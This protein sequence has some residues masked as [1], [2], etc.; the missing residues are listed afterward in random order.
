MI[1]LIEKM[2]AIYQNTDK[3]DII[4]AAAQRRLGLFG[5]EKT[6]MSE[7]AGDVSMS[8]AAL[9]YYFPDKES[10][11]KAVIEKE[12]VDFFKRIKPVIESI[13]SPQER[14]MAYVKLRIGYFREFMNLSKFRI[15]NPESATPMLRELFHKFRSQESLYF[16]ELL[17]Y[18]KDSGVFH[19]ENAYALSQLFLDILKGLRLA[20][21]PHKQYIELKEEEIDLI[22]A[23]AVE[24]TEIFIRGLLYSGSDLP[25]DPV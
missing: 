25:V 12:L 8:K 13:Q 17:Q 4:I 1:V 10:I 14:L 18:G 19:F 21:V 7:I 20:L 11:F 16:T 15:S 9:Y 5:Y 24:F 3:Y 22:L 2:E 23:R 6:T